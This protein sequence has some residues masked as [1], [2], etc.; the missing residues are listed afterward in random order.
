LA[1]NGITHIAIVTESGSKN[2]PPAAATPAAEP[3]K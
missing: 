2:A 3:V 1:T